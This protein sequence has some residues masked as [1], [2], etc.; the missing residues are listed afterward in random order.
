MVNCRQVSTSFHSSF[1]WILLLTLLTAASCTVPRKYQAGKPFVFQTNIDVSR[2]LKVSERQDMEARLYNQLDDSLKV[3][4]VSF[5]GIRKTLISPA[6]FDTVYVTRTLRYMNALLY[7]LGYFHPE[8]TWDSTL[9]QVREQQ[10]VYVNFNVNPGRVLKLDSINF[11]LDDT[12]L[13]RLADQH[14][15][16]SLLKKGDPYRQQVVASELDRLIDVYKDNGYFKISKE[17][18]YAE[19]DTVAAALINPGLDP[20]EQLRLLEALRLRRE[21]PTINIVIKQRTRNVTHLK[22]YSIGNVSIYPDL[23][24]FEDT[25]AVHFDTTQVR[26]ITI[27]SK[28]NLFKP[29]FLARNTNLLPGRLYKLSEYYK[30]VNTFS[31][32]GAWEDVNVELVPDDSASLLDVKINLYPGK[33]RNLLVDLE[34][35]RS[36]GDVIAISNFFGVGFNVGLRNRNLARESIQSI[37]N[38]RAGVE[39]GSKTRLIQTLQGSVEKNIIL[40]RFILPFRIPGESRLASS[41]TVFKFNASYI[42]RLAFFT[43]ASVYGTVGY[44]WTKNNRSWLY[45]PLNIQFVRINPRVGLV[46]LLNQVPNLRFSFQGGMIV[47]QS[48]VYKS[49][50]SNANKLTSLTAGFEESG[51]LLGLIQSIDRK[52]GLFRYARVDFDY[53]HTINYN[54][55]ALAF[56]TYAGA[57][58][59]YGR[60]SD[61]RKETSLPFIKSF[62]A[63]GPNSMRAWQIRRLGPGSSAIPQEFDRFGEI[64]LEGNFEFRFNVATIGALKLKSAL[65]TDIGN[66]WNR[67]EGEPPLENSNFQFNRLYQDLAVAAGTSLR[68]DFDYFLIRFDWGYKI[69][70]PG[71]DTLTGLPVRN[72]GW[73]RDLT[74][75][76]GQFQLGIN[77]PF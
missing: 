4:L 32:L 64:A 67:T 27:F 25:S 13:Q 36:S 31:V 49:I 50:K 24:L 14:R 62:F 35:T 74:L 56:R 8:I 54:K 37:T 51:A 73:F 28:E 3:K 39:L 29:R 23:R 34:A 45:S 48:L 22:K 18:F 70:N 55:T 12:A 40:P 38:V 61:G 69:K 7:S 15:G 47:S 76:S 19:H 72:K 77:Y 9:R 63:G 52:G 65:F 16:A 26:G 71:L 43:L 5:A 2:N 53:R 11:I 75:T 10:R 33:K 60:Q 68:F 17:D 1:Y 57:G 21:N 59:P 46:D 41:R 44:E 42:D 66:I 20:F 6:V 58:L 30:T